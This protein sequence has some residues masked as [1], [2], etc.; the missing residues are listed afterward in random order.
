M[1][2]KK[3]RGPVD[4]AEEGDVYDGEG[5]GDGVGQE[6]DAVVLRHVGQG[7]LRHH[8][9]LN[10]EPGWENLNQG[11]VPQVQ[12][13]WNTNCSVYVWD[14]IIPRKVK[15]YHSPFHVLSNPDL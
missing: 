1:F 7:V 10:S 15:E 6:P 12:E 4:A 2:L 14:F 3:T 13:K 9:H 5:V 11:I 8:P